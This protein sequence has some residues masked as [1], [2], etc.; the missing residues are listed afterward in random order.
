M[1]RFYLLTILIAFVAGVYNFKALDRAAKSIV[2]LLIITFITE[3]VAQYVAQKYHNNLPVYN[4]FNPIELFFY[5]IYFNF[6]VDVFKRKNIGWY[7]GGL[8]I[9]LGLINV[10]VRSVFLFNSYYLLFEGL[11]VIAMSLFALFRLLIKNDSL[12]FTLY[13]H[14]WFPVIFLMFWSVTFLNWGLYDYFSVTLKKGMLYIG[15]AIMLVNILTYSTIGLI[16]F[17]FPKMHL[18]HVKR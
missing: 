14:F 7:I 17:L 8:A 5:C 18:K 11:V 6:S 3:C 16:L 4:F 10:I 12:K 1:A 2:I 13:A 15:W 9:V